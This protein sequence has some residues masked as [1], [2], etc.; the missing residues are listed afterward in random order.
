MPSIFTN[1]SIVILDGNFVCI[2]PYLGTN[3]HL[4]SDVKNSKIE[5][6]NKKF[7]NFKS[8]KK[9]YLDNKLVKNIKIS[10]FKKF[11]KNSKKY[12]PILNK[13]KYYGSF[14]VVR[15]IDYETDRIK[16]LSKKIY[17]IYSGKW[18]TAVSTTI[19]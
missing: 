2:D 7:V 4:L 15:A 11:I 16:K 10:L 5:I 17:T 18:I 12:L 14:F 3:L 9:K 1:T 8:Y 19:N 13:A 6:Q